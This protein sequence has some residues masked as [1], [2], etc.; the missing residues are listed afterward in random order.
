M[1]ARLFAVAPLTLIHARGLR[2][3]GI[4]LVAGNHFYAV[5]LPVDRRVVVAVIVVVVV[6]MMRVM[7]HGALR[8]R[9][10]R[11]RP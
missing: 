5:Q 9:V 8:K 2:G 1:P 10:D 4:E 3:V 7:A 6:R 11:P